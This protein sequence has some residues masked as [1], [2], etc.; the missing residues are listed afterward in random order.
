MKK[1][2]LDNSPMIFTQFYESTLY[3]GK[4]IRVYNRDMMEI[5]PMGIEILNFKNVYLTIR[6]T[7]EQ[8]CE[9]AFFDRCVSI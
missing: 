5:R 3:P 8:R 6:D 2:Y 1:I 4:A 9:Q 7:T